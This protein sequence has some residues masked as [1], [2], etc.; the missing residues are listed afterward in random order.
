M[1]EGRITILDP[2]SLQYRGGKGVALQTCN[3]AQG[4][5]RMDN[6]GPYDA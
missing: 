6:R 3:F 5:G 1:G 4:G 2:M